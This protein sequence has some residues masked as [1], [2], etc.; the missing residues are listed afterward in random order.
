[1]EFC[2]NIWQI[3]TKSALSWHLWI[4]LSGNIWLI[5]GN[6]ALPPIFTPGS[7]DEK[8][9]ASQHTQT[10][11]RAALMAALQRLDWDLFRILNRTT[12]FATTSN[13]QIL[14]V[15]RWTLQSSRKVLPYI[16]QILQRPT[17]LR[18]YLTEVK[19]IVDIKYVGY[20]IGSSPRWL[21]VCLSG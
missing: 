21:P 7:R 13:S 19:S 5:L 16:D 14:V 18:I 8:P 1:M 15:K 20:V 6:A 4:E 10:T 3:L 9:G 11:R 17:S 2:L 12:L